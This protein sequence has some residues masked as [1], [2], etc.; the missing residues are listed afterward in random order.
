MFPQKV[1]PT[2]MLFKGIRGSALQEGPQQ[3]G[4][5][6][7]D[8][9]TGIINGTGTAHSLLLAVLFNRKDL[10]LMQETLHWGFSTSLHL[11]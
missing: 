2:Q 6:P 8:A 4:L 3:K 5:Q 1:I 9:I 7:T 10:L 11:V